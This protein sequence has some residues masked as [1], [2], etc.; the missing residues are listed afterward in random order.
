MSCDAESSKMLVWEP[1]PVKPCDQEI[2]EEYHA[3]SPL[4]LF[5]IIH[6]FSKK[7]W[8]VR[9]C[10]NTGDGYLFTQ[11]LHRGYTFTSLFHAQ[12]AAQTYIEKGFVY[13]V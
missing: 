10:V 4:I 1:V 6:T 7:S 5:S 13:V 12:R 2:Y 3:A 8:D 11:P 9:V